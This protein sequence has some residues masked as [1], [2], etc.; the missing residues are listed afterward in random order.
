MRGEGRSAGFPPWSGRQELP[1]ARM[2]HGDVK[3][4]ETQSFSGLSRVTTVGVARLQPCAGCAPAPPWMASALGRQPPK[5]KKTQGTG[6]FFMI[7]GRQSGFRDG[8]IRP[9]ART[10][11]CVF[12][13][14]PES[15]WAI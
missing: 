10:G 1:A 3:I 4:G 9:A 5:K 6:G 8:R 7:L 12:G 11:I 13:K 15:D 2:R 14:I